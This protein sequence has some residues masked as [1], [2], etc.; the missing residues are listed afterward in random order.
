MKNEDESIICPKCKSNSI[1]EIF[2]GLPNFT[3]ELNK[4]I[5]DK[6]I[7]LGGCEISWDNP[8]YHCNDCKNEF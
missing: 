4:K 7:V 2:Y 3:E 8:I 5:E 1:A 6:K